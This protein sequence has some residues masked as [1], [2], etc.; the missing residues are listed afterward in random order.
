[1]STPKAG[2]PADEESKEDPEAV[3]VDQALEMLPDKEDFETEF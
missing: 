1:M 3:S 2:K